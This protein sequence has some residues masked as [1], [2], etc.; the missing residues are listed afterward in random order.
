MELPSN[1]K[2]WHFQCTARGRQWSSELRSFTGNPVHLELIHE[3]A[4]GGIEIDTGK[5]VIADLLWRDATLNR[6]YEVL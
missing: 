4:C 2:L 3:S 5:V 1:S 6:P